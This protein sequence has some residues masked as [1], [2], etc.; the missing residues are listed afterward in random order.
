MVLCLIGPLLAN[1][2]AF[3]FIPF[4]SLRVSKSLTKALK[5]TVSIGL[6]TGL[7][8]VSHTSFAQTNATLRV[9]VHSSFSLPKPLIAQ[10]ETENKV[11][12]AIT[13]GGDAGEMLNKLILTKANPIAD[14]VYGIDNTLAQKAIQANILTPYNGPAATQASVVQLPKPIIPIDYGYVSLNID[15]AAF[16]KL[17]L[18]MPQSLH[19][20]T[21]PAYKNKLVVENPNT[22]STGY[23]FLLATIA[24]LGEDQAFEWWAKMRQNGMKVSKGWSEAYYTDFARN[25][26][27]YPIIVSYASSPAAEVFYSKEKLNESPTQNLFLKGS[28]FQQVEGV[29]LIKGGS[30]AELAGK[31]IEWLRSKPVQEAL[32]TSMWMLPVDKSV[33][34]ADAWKHTQTPSSFDNPKE[35]EVIVQSTSWLQRWTK[36]V[37]K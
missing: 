12:L 15:K 7:S 23:S 21:L 3:M 9:M 28:V 22:S 35:S 31:W 6:L 30:Q 14:V 18:A 37:L 19:D 4:S 13:K 1:L 27:P 24:G 2:G 25:G 11:K 34:V 33:A 16:A 32:Q 29:A 36:V 26:G 5:K 17:K 8:V 10:F 20:L